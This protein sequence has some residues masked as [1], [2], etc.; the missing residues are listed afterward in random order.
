MPQDRY[1]PQD[2]TVCNIQNNSY[3]GVLKNMTLS[4]DVESADARGLK[5]TYKYAWATGRGL[6]F[7][8]T[9]HA[10]DLRRAWHRPRD[11][12]GELRQRGLHRY[13]AH[14]VRKPQGRHGRF[15]GS[16]LYA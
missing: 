8:G 14:H 4:I 11:V 3:L 5:D 6:K 16:E 1:A 15:A 13:R 7:E 2:I 12:R 9:Q 10:S